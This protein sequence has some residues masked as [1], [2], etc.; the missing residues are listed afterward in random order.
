[1]VPGGFDQQSPGMTVAGL[2]DRSLAAGA[3]GGVLAG[4]EADERADAG[5]AEPGPVTDLDR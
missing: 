2:G 3:A 4:G 1:M 5:T